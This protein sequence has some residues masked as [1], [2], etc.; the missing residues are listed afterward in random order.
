MIYLLLVRLGY[1]LGV[2]L[3]PF[4]YSLRYYCHSIKRGIVTSFYKNKLSA[5]GKGTLL[6]PKMWIVNPQYIY[7]GDN[8]DV[9]GYVTLEAHPLPPDFLRPSLRIGNNVSIGEYCHITCCSNIIIEDGVLFGRFIL[10]TDNAHGASDI[11]EI[12]IQPIKREL[13]SKGDVFVGRNVWIG[14]KSTILPGVTIGEGC[15]IAANSVVT[16]DVPPFSVV[17]G[18]PAAIVKKIK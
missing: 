16:K 2:F 18:N 13:V 8:S 6:S 17:A 1:V 4:H 3:R 9:A 10:I 15:I 5:I 14:D 12:A 11:K 7:I